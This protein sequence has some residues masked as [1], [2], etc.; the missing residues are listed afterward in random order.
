MTT[1]TVSVALLLMLL[2]LVCAIG[3]H[4]LQRAGRDAQGL[5]RAAIGIAGLAVVFTAILTAA[6]T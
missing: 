3:G 1:L 6:A 5:F 4:L 2:A